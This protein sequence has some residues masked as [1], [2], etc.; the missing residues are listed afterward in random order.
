MR[1]LIDRDIGQIALVTPGDPS[2]LLQGIERVLAAPRDE[3]A[4]TDLLERISPDAIGRRLKADI[5]EL[6][7]NRRVVIHNA[8]HA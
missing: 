3:F 6:I 1:E 8:G 5:E 7:A 4:Y 2:A